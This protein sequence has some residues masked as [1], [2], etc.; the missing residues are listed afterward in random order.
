MG[1]ITYKSDVGTGTWSYHATKKHAVISAAGN[2]FSYDANGNQITR[3][4]DTISWTSYNY[5]S[6]I[7][8][9]SRYHDYYYGADRQRWKQVYF[10]GTASETTILVGGILEK[11][12]AGSLTEYRHYIKVGSQAVALYTRPS[13]GSPTTQYF[14]LD[15]LGSV[16]EITN[17]AGSVDVS[18]SFSA[19]GQRRDPTDWSGPISSGDLSNIGG[20]TP[21]GYTFH[22]N[23][24]SSSL[25]HMN[26]RV[27]DSLTGR[28]LSPDPYVPHPEVT[29]SFNRYSYVRNNPLSL[30]DP[31][32]FWDVVPQPPGCW[33]SPQCLIGYG[34]INSIFAYGFDAIFG[35]SDEPKIPNGCWV[36]ANGCYGRAGSLKL[37]QV[38]SDVVKTPGTDLDI[39]QTEP[40]FGNQMVNGL[41]DFVFGRA[42][43]QGNPTT[44]TPARL[45]R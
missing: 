9:G 5:P 15:H 2:S 18:E 1:N 31:S 42:E 23:L 32:G 21:R 37:A 41:L 30:T 10:N 27:A 44:L 13:S 34:V 22:T 43:A 3:N 19:F 7:S 24:E 26:G 39:S 33:M 20:I 11:H 6:H 14:L 17:S 36:Q 28:F 38:A 12:T 40:T 45:R 4:G 16:A 25:I 35:G 29:Q 8:N